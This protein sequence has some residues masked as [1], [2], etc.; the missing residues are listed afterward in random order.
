MAVVAAAAGWDTSYIVMAV[1]GVVATL[2]A[3]PIKKGFVEQ[4]EERFAKE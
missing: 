4:A 3:L 1:L 2:V